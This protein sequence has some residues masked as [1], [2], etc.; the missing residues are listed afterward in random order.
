MYLS[1]LI[2]WENVLWQGALLIVSLRGGQH[3][4]TLALP[5]FLFATIWTLIFK[6]H[7]FG[8]VPT[9]FTGYEFR[10]NMN[11]K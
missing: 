3:G 10:V 11:D 5:L 4:L 1:R 9:C 2:K 7:V 8:F 6:P